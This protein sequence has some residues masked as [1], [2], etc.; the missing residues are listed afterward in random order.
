MDEVLKLVSPEM[1]ALVL[2]VNLALQAVLAGLKKGLDLIK[3]K[4]ATKADDKAAEVIGYILKPVDFI[5]KLL[6]GNADK[7]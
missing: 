4:T 1:I 2:M 6:Q 5:V 3:A 7:K